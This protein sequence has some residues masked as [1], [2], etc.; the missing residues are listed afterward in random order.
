[1][2]A[3]MDSVDFRSE[4]Q[5]GT[6]VRLVKQLSFDDAAAAARV[7]LARADPGRRPAR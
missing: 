1:M 2:E 4:P 6:L 3:L 7:L 5:Q